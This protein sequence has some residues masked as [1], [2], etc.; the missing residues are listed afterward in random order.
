[1][2]DNAYNMIIKRPVINALGPIVSTLHLALKFPLKDGQIATIDANQQE[3][4]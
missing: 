3:A 4:R 1:M 2:T